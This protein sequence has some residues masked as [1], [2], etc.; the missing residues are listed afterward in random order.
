MIILEPGGLLAWILVGLLAGFIASALTGR[1]DI[2]ILASMALG[3]VGAVVGQLVL[4]LFVE[5]ER[6]RFIGSVA[7]ATVGALLVLVVAN[8]ARR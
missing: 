3:L 1:R 4:E 8:L 5:Y 2:G 6:V 7:V